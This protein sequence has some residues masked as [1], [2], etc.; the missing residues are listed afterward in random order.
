M[1]TFS[2][3]TYVIMAAVITGLTAIPFVWIYIVSPI[4]TLIHEYGHAI[5]NIFTLGRPTGI[6]VHFANGGGET[7]HIRNVGFFNFFGRIISGISGYTAPIILGFAMLMSIRVGYYHALAV[8]ILISFIVFLFL[9]RNIAGWIIGIL[10]VL[11]F[12][13]VVIIEE[14][15][16]MWMILLSGMVFIVGG[17]VDMLLLTKRYFQQ[18]TDE[19][20]LGIL[21]ETNHLPQIIW[22]LAMYGQVFL[23]IWLL[24]KIQ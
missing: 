3:T 21:Q 4:I 13:L 8:G 18:D 1:E 10:G 6:R 12:G 22:L 11:Y 20:D 16:G 23:G 5:S 15:T 24:L 14:N 7:H 17:V 2:V 9:M 19:T